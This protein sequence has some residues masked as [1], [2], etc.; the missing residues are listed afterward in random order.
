[1]PDIPNEFFGFNSFRI[2]IF[3]MEEQ[4]IYQYL[5][6]DELLRISNKIKFWEK[7]TAG[8]ICVSIKERRSFLRKNKLLKQ[9]AEEEFYRL[10]VDKTK[11]ATGILI[12]ILLEEKQFYIL[13]DK[14]INERVP[15]N[16]WDKIKN[17]MQTLFIK[18]EFS[19]GIIYGVEEIGKILNTHFPIKPDD[20]NELSN[21]VAIT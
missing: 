4:L 11:D 5:N 15:N 21:R 7:L 18:G 13:A 1:L 19:K 3:N 8:E 9:L 16:T 12:F 2:K 20:T 14:G 17:Q 6:D 10:G